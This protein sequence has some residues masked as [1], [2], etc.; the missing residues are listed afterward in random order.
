M[1]VFTEVIIIALDDGGGI[2]TVY[3]LTI[4]IVFNE[5]MKTKINESKEKCHA[6]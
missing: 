4:V 5:S 1:I 2:D 6:N 3:G